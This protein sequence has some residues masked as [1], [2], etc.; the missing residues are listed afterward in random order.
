ML[1]FNPSTT[2][3]P[4][5]FFCL[6]DRGEPVLIATLSFSSCSSFVLQSPGAVRTLS[7]T[8]PSYSLTP[9]TFPPHCLRFCLHSLC[10][11]TERA[12][13]GRSERHNLHLSG[14]RQRPQGIKADVTMSIRP[15]PTTGSKDFVEKSPPRYNDQPDPEKSAL[16][17]RSDA[18]KRDKVPDVAAGELILDVE[19]DGV[20]QRGLKSRHAQMIALG[21]TIGTGLFVGSGQTLAR[22]GPAFILGCYTVMAFGV[23]CVVSGIVELAA[24]VP[25]PGCSMN[26]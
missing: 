9:L 19:R 12:K 17:Q 24:W 11:L 6:K 26:L 5:Y 15:D 22:G 13:G 2:P 25:T 18:A 10:P 16:R 21:G 4:V 8:L 7:N 14:K 20:T 1:G 23:W 3:S